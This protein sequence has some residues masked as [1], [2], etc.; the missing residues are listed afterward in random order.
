MRELH[1]AATV[2]IQHLI[3]SGEEVPVDEQFEVVV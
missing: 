3:E 2:V 1:D